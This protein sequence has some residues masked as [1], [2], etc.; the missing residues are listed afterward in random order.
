MMVYSTLIVINQER[1]LRNIVDVYLKSSAQYPAQ[2]K[3]V[4]RLE[5]IKKEIEKK[6]KNLKTENVTMIVYKLMLQPHLK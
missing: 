5:S 6:S 1:G 4:N 3:T 2:V